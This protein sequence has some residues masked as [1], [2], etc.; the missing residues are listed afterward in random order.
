MAVSDEHLC[1]HVLARSRKWLPSVRMFTATSDFPAT[2]RR[3][4]GLSGHPV[5]VGP[6]AEE[7]LRPWVERARPGPI[8]LVAPAPGRI[9]ISWQLMVSPGPCL[10]SFLRFWPFSLCQS[11]SFRRHSCVI[12]RTGHSMMCW[13]TA[14]LFQ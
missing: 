2:L 12:R 6:C 5:H 4:R 11:F 8:S 7:E 13:D 3:E 1:V 14:H 10:T 9:Q